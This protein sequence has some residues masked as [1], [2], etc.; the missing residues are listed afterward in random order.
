MY[1]CM[2]ETSYLPVM[3]FASQ[4]LSCSTSSKVISTHFRGMKGRNANSMASIGSRNLEEGDREQLLQCI[5]NLAR[6]NKWEEVEC[7]IVKQGSTF[8]EDL[9]RYKHL[10]RTI[11]HIAAENRNEKGI[12]RCLQWG[13]DVD[14]RDGAGIHSFFKRFSL[15]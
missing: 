4:K 7:L 9:S 2:M 8:L 15:R 3:L 12:N 6:R 1:I 5:F 10:N 13:I 14:V 11:L